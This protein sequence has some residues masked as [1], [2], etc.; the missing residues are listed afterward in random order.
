MTTRANRAPDPASKE[1][2]A[3][4]HYNMDVPGIWLMGM[5]RGL[6]I[7]ADGALLRCTAHV[8]PGEATM[9]FHEVSSINVNGGWR[10]RAARKLLGL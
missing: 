4:A 8:K 10:A 5:E 6:Y 1:I 3:G 2:K 7:R 9:V